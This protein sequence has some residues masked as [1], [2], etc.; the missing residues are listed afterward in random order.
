[1]D[2]QIGNNFQGAIH[3]S[4]ACFIEKMG[5]IDE[6]GAPIKWTIVERTTLYIFFICFM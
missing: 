3:V 6:L 5:N 2:N 4:F 1:M